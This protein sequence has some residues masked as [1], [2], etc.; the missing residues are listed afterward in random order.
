MARS[1]K[2]QTALLLDRLGRHE[3]HVRPGDRFA[4]RLCVRGVILL[5]LT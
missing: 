4:N 5:P 1:M 2:H 3:P